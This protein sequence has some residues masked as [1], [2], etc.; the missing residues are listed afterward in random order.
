MFE[1]QTA[2]AILD[3]VRRRVPEHHAG[4]IRRVHICLGDQSPVVAETLARS[5][6]AAVAGTRYYPAMLAFRRAPGSE[7]TVREIDL[8][9]GLPVL[10][11][12]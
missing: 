1:M 7:L 10:H 9:D 6:A 11:A 5:F 8:E 4:N 12:A 2:D 3:V